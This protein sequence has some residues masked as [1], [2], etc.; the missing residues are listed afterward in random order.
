MQAWDRTKLG[1]MFDEWH[2]S[3]KLHGSFS[4]ETLKEVWLHYHMLVDQVRRFGLVLRPLV[5]AE[6]ITM[7]KLLE[8]DGTT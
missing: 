3:G 8:D 7:E 4:K 6:G 2:I 5:E 1:S